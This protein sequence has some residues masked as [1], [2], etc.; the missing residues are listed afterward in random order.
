LNLELLL[1]KGLL[2]MPIAKC[3]VSILP[4]VLLAG[5]LTLA[6]GCRTSDVTIHPPPDKITPEAQKVVRI[7]T[8]EADAAE[9]AIAADGGGSLYLVY[10]E[11]LPDKGAD[12]FV[13]KL[14][15]AAKPVG[16]RVRVNPEPG[17]AKA[18]R[19][20]PP[21]IVIGRDNAVYIG[22][23]RALSDQRSKGNNLVLSISRDGALT[24][25]AP[26]TVNDD[27]KP[28]SHGMHSLAVDGTNRIYMAWLDERN[29]R[30]EEHHSSGEMTMSLAA[31]HHEEAEPNSEVYF[32]SSIDGGQSFTPNKKIAAEVCPCCKTSLLAAADGVVYASWRQVLKGDHRHIAVARSSDGGERFS[33]TSIV[34]D[35]NWQISACPVSGASLSS[36]GSDEL[37]VIWYTAGAAGQPGVYLARSTDGGQTFGPRLFVSGAAT[38]GTPVLLPAQ[39]GREMAVF[40]GVNGEIVTAGWQGIPANGF[41]Q[42]SI[43]DADLP[44]AAMSGGK[45]FIAFVRMSG[46]KHA[47]WVAY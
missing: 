30:T 46:E 18:W 2:T 28:A 43:V 31:M 36:V 33:R 9:P 10:V 34:S 37:D 39:A 1:L 22:W 19:G 16:E 8:E 35:D 7:S 44:A 47:V 38:S 3:A 13:Q 32:A 26:V 23:T 15:A 45:P 11:H 42:N 25:T 6:A 24:F 40:A 29:V 21:T 14:D 17:T 41:G 12:V 5:F 27:R 4:V 20:D